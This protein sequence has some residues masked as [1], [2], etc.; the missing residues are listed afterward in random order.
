MADNKLTC[1]N[2]KDVIENFTMINGMNPLTT[3]DDQDTINYR[4]NLND[5]P[6]ANLSLYHNLNKPDSPSTYED[7]NKSLHTDQ[8]GTENIINNNQ[9]WRNKYFIYY[10]GSKINQS[11]VPSNYNDFKGY[12]MAEFDKNQL[13]LAINPTRPRFNTKRAFDEQNIYYDDIVQTSN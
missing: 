10:D 2:K 1:S 4:F 13:H 11:L 9:F 8:I 12:A 7:N 5:L 3:Y 6:I